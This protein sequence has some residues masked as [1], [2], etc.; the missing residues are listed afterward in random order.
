MDLVKFANTGS[1]NAQADG[2]GKENEAGGGEHSATI[3][4]FRAGPF[5]QIW[6][7]SEANAKSGFSRRKSRAES[8]S[9]GKTNCENGL[10]DPR[11][12]R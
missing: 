7:P 12:L 2:L 5:S 3:R 9:T 10:A 1:E 6:R 8:I 4:P 11:S